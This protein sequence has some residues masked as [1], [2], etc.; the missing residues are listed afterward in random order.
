MKY[1]L[2]GGGGFI[3][4]HL[5]K[6]LVDERHEILIID[7]FDTSPKVEGPNIIAADIST[8]PLLEEKIKWA[9]VVYFLAGSVGVKKIVT[10]PHE[11]IMN[12]V[13]LAAAVIPLVAKHNK[14]TMFTSTS[15]VYGNGPFIESESASIG[16]TDNLRW[17]YASAKLTTEF[18]LASSGAPFQ[19]L[20]LF[21]IVGPG[22]IGDHGMVLPRFITSAKR[23]EDIIIHGDGLQY[24]SFCHVSDALDIIRQLEKAPCGVYNIGNDVPT[25]ILELANTVKEEVKSS[26]NLITKSLEEVYV[27]NGGDIQRRIP[28]L[29]KLKNTINYNI[30]YSLIDIIRDML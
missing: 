5:A 15:E 6:R 7:S 11:S 20:R 19:I 2:L 12:N 27:K 3:G 8:Y 26:S 21:N 29:T 17:S 10:W 22:Q 16:P 23:N 28:N 1:L 24:R 13:A 18:M 9:D 25:T 14:L 30:N 4:T